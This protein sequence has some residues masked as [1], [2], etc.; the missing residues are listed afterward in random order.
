MSERSIENPDVV[1]DVATHEPPESS[2]PQIT[3]YV[4]PGIA[5][6]KTTSTLPTAVR[7]T[8]AMLSWFTRVAPP[9]VSPTCACAQ[10]FPLYMR[11]STAQICSH[12]YAHPM[13]FPLGLIGFGALCCSCSP[14]AGSRRGSSPLSVAG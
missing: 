6:V 5:R 14:N 7:V 11:C 1:R 9:P 13:R 2:T 10:L 4:L 3:E 8:L 12:V